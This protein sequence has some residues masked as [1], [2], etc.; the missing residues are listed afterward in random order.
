MREVAATGMRWPVESAILECKS[1]LGL[2]QYEVRG[3]TAWHRHVT[4]AMLGYAYLAGIRARAAD[5]GRGENRRER[6]RGA[7]RQPAASHGAR[8][9]PP[10]LAPHLGRRP[11]ARGRPRVVA[12]APRAP[13]ARSPLPLAATN[14]LH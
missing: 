9:A 5:G 13:A 3:W 8:G 11:R 2:D 14:T 6:R 4:L 12:L 1:E 7:G 10:A